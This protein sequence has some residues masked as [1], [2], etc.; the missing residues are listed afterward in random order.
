MSLSQRLVRVLEAFAQILVLNQQENDSKDW[1]CSHT[2]IIIS[3][4]Q[5]NVFDSHNC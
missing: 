5:K 1:G 3:N 4:S 2:V